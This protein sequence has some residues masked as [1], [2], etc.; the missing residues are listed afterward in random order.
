MFKIRSFCVWNWCFSLSQACHSV[1][2]SLF[3]LYFACLSNIFLYFLYF[4]KFLSIF[5][6]MTL[7]SWYFFSRVAGNCHF[8]YLSC[9]IDY[10]QYYLL[11]NISCFIDYNQ[12]YL[13]TNISCFI[14][15]NKYFCYH[16][17]LVSRRSRW[18]PKDSRLSVRPYVRM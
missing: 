5:W 13:L 11:T 17:F 16:L 7:F 2:Y 14:D 8:A 9:C 18:R 3:V 1:L 12:Y 15:Y 10:N 6:L 4:C